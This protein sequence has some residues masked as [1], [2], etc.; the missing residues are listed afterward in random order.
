M[1]SSDGIKMKFS[2]TLFALFLSIIVIV[3]SSAQTKAPT[4]TPKPTPTDMFDLSDLGDYLGT[5]KEGSSA[6]DIFK[7]TQLM[8]ERKYDD[9]IKIFNESLKADDTN[10]YIRGYRALA[11][12]Y[13]R[14]LDKALIDATAS[15]KKDPIEVRALDVRAM[16][17]RDRGKSEAAKKDF[18]LAIEISTKAIKARP[19]SMDDYFARAETYRLMGENA[20]AAADYRKTLELSPAYNFADT[21]LKLVTGVQQPK[22]GVRQPPIVD[23]ETE[24][25]AHAKEFER[26]APLLEE[27]GD[28]ADAY[29][30]ALKF[31]NKKNNRNAYFRAAADNSICKALA[32]YD[33][34]YDLASAEANAMADMVQSGASEKTSDLAVK[35]SDAENTIEGLGGDILTR[36]MIWKCVAEKTGTTTVSPPPVT[37]LKSRTKAAIDKKDYDT[38]L[39]ELNGLITKDKKN[40]EAFAL[41][42]DIYLAQTKTELARADYNQAIKLSPKTSAYYYKRGMSFLENPAYSILTAMADYSKAIELDP[43]NSDA[44]KQRGLHYMMDLQFAPAKSDFL[45]VLKLTPNDA[46]VNYRLGRIYVKENNADAA[47]A[48]FSTSI[49]ADPKFPWVYAERGEV[50]EYLNKNNEAIADYSQ[51]I[52]LEP[53]LP[54][55]Y[56]DR[57]RL[58]VKLKD[59]ALGVADMTKIISFTDRSSGDYLRRGDIYVAWGKYDEALA[60]YQSAIYMSPN[61]P[62]PKKHYNDLVPIINAARATA[63]TMSAIYN[64]ALAAYT[65]IEKE[66][67]TRVDTYLNLKKSKDASPATGKSPLCNHI[68]YLITLTDKAL[69]AINPIQLLFLKGSLKGFS[70]QIDFIEDREKR[71]ENTKKMLEKDISTFSCQTKIYYVE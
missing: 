22:I 31:D 42:G 1:D 43:T 63:P 19:G 45:A 34:L 30:N 11:Y 32:D 71:L 37:D 21:H 41:R 50:Y 23:D 27:A 10:A 57:S 6:W 2:T 60:D 3:N 70:E 17:E 18:E 67:S 13:K 15:L 35:A 51:T 55:G 47:I 26:L 16:I 52:R 4:P 14:D 9:A 12:Y 66:L 68:P 8:E 5:I 33:A 64:P 54:A 61:D 44:Y 39:S 49:K 58:Y 7:V 53:N 36:Q 24:F 38:I 46:Q 25:Q 62:A 28:K 65:P 69:V 20:K 56:Y 48:C 40:S 59:Y 29:E